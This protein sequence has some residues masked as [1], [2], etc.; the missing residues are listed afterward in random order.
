MATG[1]WEDS[2]LDGD[3]TT[4]PSGDTAAG[5]ESEYAITYKWNVTV[6]DWLDETVKEMT[7]QVTWESRGAER[8]VT[9]TTLVYTEEV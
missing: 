2:S 9:L 8:E 6:E 7:V 5:A 4:T 3:F 1:A